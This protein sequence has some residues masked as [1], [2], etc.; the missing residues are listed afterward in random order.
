[1]PYNLDDQGGRSSTKITQ[2]VDIW[3]LG[4]IFSEAA[5][6]IADG[7]KG[8]VDYRRQRM[9][10]TDEIPNFKGGDCFHD[11]ERVLKAVIDA[12][13]DIELRLRRSDY[14]TK[15]VLDSMVEEMLWEE[16]RP[17]AK[18][19]WRKAEGVL[20]RAE[21]K[22]AKNTA[23]DLITRPNNSRLLSYP[24][25]KSPPLPPPEL[26]R[27][28]PPGLSSFAERQYPANV[29]TWRSQVST[30]NADYAGPKTPPYSGGQRNNSE[31]MMHLDK[32]LTGSIASWQGGGSSPLASPLTSPFTSPRV[33]SQYD[34]HRHLSSE[35]RPRPRHSQRS[36]GQKR[37]N[38]F[39]PAQLHMK[40]TESPDEET[41][42][43]E[44]L[45]LDT[46]FAQD[47]TT[48]SP[49]DREEK[50]APVFDSPKA[51]GRGSQHSSSGYSIPIMRPPVQNDPPSYHFSPEDI[52]VP[53]KSQKRPQGLSLFPSATHPPPVPLA[54]VAIP[55]MKT[56]TLNDN[57][58]AH[59]ESIPQNA[60]LP[61]LEH[62]ND[63]AYSAEYLSLT[64]ALE[65]KKAHKVKKH[66]KVPS[67]PGSDLLAGLKDRDHV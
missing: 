36:S 26:P 6:W 4:C 24:V 25:P 29:E 53:P 5:M 8:V 32:E 43:S 57:A 21:Q 52:Q 55:A 40:T 42:A 45:D 60:A 35:G 31:S 12:H 63:R 65:W 7:Y 23:E 61:V 34:F 1:M 47:S 14:I 58:V 56:S 44:A 30:P 28:L 19:L 27:L 54:P 17:N 15:D 66:A 9:A 48:M 22:L 37:V 11:G 16:D 67:L 49:V 50:G 2:A 41:E 62:L 13:K 20:L 39:S 64:T 10:E 38:D 3:S 18:A 51:V 33:S 46:E 59:S